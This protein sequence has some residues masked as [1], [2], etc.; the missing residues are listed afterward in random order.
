MVNLAP[1]I[2]S[3]DFCNL[4]AQVKTVEETNTEFLHI[5]IMDGSFVPNISF[6]FP[7]IKALRKNSKMI[8]DVH[9]MIENP[10]KYIDEFVN[11]GADIIT[12]HYEAERH[13]DRTVN[14][15]K[16]KGCK[17]GIALNPATPVSV[18]KNILPSLDMVLIMSVNPG[19]GGQSFIEYS[20]DKI[21]EVKNLAKKL[22]KQN[23]LIEV[24]GGVDTHNIKS[25]VEA[26]ANVL[27]AG[28][29]V[30]RENKI[31]ENINALNE[32]LR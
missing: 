25:I 14:Y 23:L 24:D 8:F 21:Q 2:L 32:A 16:N 27:V 19:F 18:L 4:G 15:I 7:V 1:S 9:L 6:G 17:V 30:F 13:I 29:A 22:N 12:F 26:G 11:C 28:S 31:K 3:A 5:D 20:I 10:S